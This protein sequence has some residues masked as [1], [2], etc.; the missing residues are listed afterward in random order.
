MKTYALFLNGEWF[1]SK[2][3]V[4]VSPRPSRALASIAAVAFRET[5]SDLSRKNCR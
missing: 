5:S 4:P 1:E 2:T 3:T